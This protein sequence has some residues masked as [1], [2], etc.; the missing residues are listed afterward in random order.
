MRQQ[1]DQATLVAPLAFTGRDVLIDDHLRVVHE[2]AKLRFPDNQIASALK[3]VSIFKSE[4]RFLGKRRFEDREESPLRR[5]VAEGNV[6][7]LPVR[8]GRLIMPDMVAM[9][10]A[11]PTYVQAG[12]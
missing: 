10:K 12:K 8:V 3:C 1:D 2:V 4:D 5:D 11:S 9:K 6:Q 7:M